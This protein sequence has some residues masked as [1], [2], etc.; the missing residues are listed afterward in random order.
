MA[1]AGRT[2]VRK[3]I[4]FLRS[5]DGEAL[6]FPSGK[7][8]ARPFPLNPAF[9]V[10]PPLPNHLRTQIHVQ[11][12]KNAVSK[13]ALATKYGVSL[14]RINAIIKQKELEQDM[15]KR[16]EEIQEKYA[17]CMDELMYA[18]DRGQIYR[19]AVEEEHV[20][21]RIQKQV[22]VPV[23]VEDDPVTM[24]DV[25]KLLGKRT[26]LSSS[27]STLHSEDAT[28]VD[29]P[30]SEHS[31]ITKHLTRDPVIKY[32]DENIKGK[33]V[34]AFRDTSKPDG[35]PDA[36]LTREKD[37]TLRGMSVHTFNTLQHQQ[38]PC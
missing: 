8:H 35:H 22:S 15:R 31:T 6:K 3:S 24:A 28:S 16:G 13:H 25:A 37:G 38:Q 11:H 17:K 1:T 10:T 5:S 2:A 33:F 36:V 18:A 19:E 21:E 12:T 20:K 29:A 34:F 14:D 26:P 30:L 7:L 23:D 32:K 27:R 9:V 4:Q